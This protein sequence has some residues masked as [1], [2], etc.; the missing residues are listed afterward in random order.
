MRAVVGERSEAD[1]RAAERRDQRQ[2]AGKPRAE[3]LHV[4]GGRRPGLLLRL[5]VIVGRQFLDAGAENLRQQRHVLRQQ[6]PHGEFRLCLGV[7]DFCPAA[8]ACARTVSTPSRLVS[9]SLFQ[10]RRTRK[11][12]AANHRSRY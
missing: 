6:R 12:M 7:H 9:M 11:P 5:A 2:L 1:R 8:S 10:K 4:V 3:F